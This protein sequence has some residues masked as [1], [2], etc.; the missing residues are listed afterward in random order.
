MGKSGGQREN[1][2]V[3]WTAKEIER[4]HRQV[5]EVT[6]AKNIVFQRQ[7]ISQSEVPTAGY[8]NQ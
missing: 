5:D 6:S 7:A 4:L 3:R 2:E 8:I 1:R